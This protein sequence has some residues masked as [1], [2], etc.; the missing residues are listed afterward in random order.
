MCL[1]TMKPHKIY[2]IKFALSTSDTMEGKRYNRILICLC[3]FCA[4]TMVLVMSM[5]SVY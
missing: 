1:H 5:D 3:Y 4:F 2:G